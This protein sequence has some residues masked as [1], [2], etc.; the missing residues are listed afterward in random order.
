MVPACEEESGGWG[1]GEPVGGV[2]PQQGGEGKPQT[3]KDGG[4][5]L[6]EAGSEQQ[7]ERHEKVAEKD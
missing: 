2:T 5:C 4:R 7:K 3:G 6:V 1:G